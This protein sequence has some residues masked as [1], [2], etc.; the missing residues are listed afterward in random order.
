MR[1]VSYEKAFYFFLSIG[2]ITG[3]KAS[4]LAEFLEKV[5][6]ID[7]KSLEFHLYRKDFERWIGETLGY[8]YLAD[9]MKKIR[10][11]NLKGEGMRAQISR[12]VS[13][14]INIED[15][16]TAPKEHTHELE[17]EKQLKRIVEDNK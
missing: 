16:P 6:K 11:K 7:I 2:N 13:N 15:Y 17:M 4:S 12:A 10:N 14:F 8:D 9:E 1:K 3:E 5:K